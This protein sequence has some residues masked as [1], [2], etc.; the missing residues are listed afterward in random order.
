MTA[1]QP[2]VHVMA[3]TGA[4]YRDPL[5]VSRDGYVSFPASSPLVRDLGV[6]GVAFAWARG[7][8]DD[9]GPALLTATL[10]GILG[11]DGWS[12][13]G[14]LGRF[15]AEIPTD[16]EPKRTMPAFGG[17]FRLVR[18]IPTP[19]LQ[20]GVT[21]YVGRLRGETVIDPTPGARAIADGPG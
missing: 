6:D 19:Q 1:E 17:A 2:S 9:Q 8:T 7:A 15:D 20:K 16:A 18:R 14:L 12:T 11:P 5:L 21:R 13:L 4:I 10:D 3:R